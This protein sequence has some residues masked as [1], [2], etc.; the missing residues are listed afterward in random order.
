M[1]LCTVL[2]NHKL[3]NLVVQKFIEAKS[4]CSIWFSCPGSGNIVKWYK[5]SIL[6]HYPHSQ[7]LI[8]ITNKRQ[9][10]EVTKMSVSWSMNEA[11]LAHLHIWCIN[12]HKTCNIIHPWKVAEILPFFLAIMTLEG[13]MLKKR[14]QL[15]NTNMWSHEQTKHEVVKLMWFI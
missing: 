3:W 2:R 13:T 9:G 10:T 1:N 4:R 8:S 12:T 7:V 14:S 5:M 11:Y 6:K 15:Q